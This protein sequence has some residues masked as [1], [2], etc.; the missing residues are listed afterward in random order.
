MANK[1]GPQWSQNST[2][3]PRR[4]VY[5]RKN[6]NFEQ[7]KIMLHEQ[8]TVLG[9]ADYPLNSLDVLHAWEMDDTPSN[10]AT[11]LQARNQKIT[12]RAERR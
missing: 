1:Y 9:I 11:S 8:L 2:N 6:T 3:T 12:F 10:Y 5:T 4:T 7:W